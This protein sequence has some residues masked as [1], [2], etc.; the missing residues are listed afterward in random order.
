MATISSVLEEAS[1]I[2]SKESRYTQGAFARDKNGKVV[3]A[4]SSHAVS[5]DAIGA[6]RKAAGVD[7]ETMR[8]SK[9]YIA[10][11]AL[12]YR[13]NKYAAICQCSDMGHEEACKLLKRA[14]GL[15]NR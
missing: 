15:V 10:A 4:V 7:D 9:V 2:L 3:D 6:I 5:W 14:Q 1:K 11:A 13:A 8:K 12:V